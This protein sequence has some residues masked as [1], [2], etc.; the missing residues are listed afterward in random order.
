M[1][2]NRS[3]KEY[4]AVHIFNTFSRKIEAL[5]T[6]EAGL[7]KI[8]CCGPTVYESPHIGNMRTYIWQDI[9]RRTL[10]L[11][12][13]EVL[14]V[15]NITDVGHLKSDADTGEDKLQESA[16]RR[17]ST[18]WDIA[19][20]YTGEFFNYS[21]VLNIKDPSVSPMATDH[22]N[23][24]L[25]LIKKLDDNGYT[26]TIR[27]DGVYYDTSKFKD[28]GKLTGMNF[29]QLNS[30]LIGGARVELSKDKRNITDFALWKFSPKNE[31]RDM[32]WDSGYGIGFPGWHIECSAMSMKY[33]G[34]TIDVHCGGVDHIYI[35][36]PNE[37][38][39][40][41]G[42]TGKKFVNYWMHGEF[43]LVEN[44]KMS[45][46]MGNFYT[47]ADILKKGFGWREIR[48]LLFSA[49]Y[50]SQLNFTFR[51]LE[52]AKASIMRIQG[53]MRRLNRI[54]KSDDN[55]ELKKLRTLV[56][57]HKNEFL[58][59]MNNDIMVPE[60]LRVVFDLISYI[61]KQIEDD[62]IGKAGA[63]EV[64]GTMLFFDSVLGLNL[65]EL[66]GEDKV[67]QEV[68]ELL[69]KRDIARVKSDYALADEIRD[70]ILDKYGFIIED[71]K[72]GQRLKKARQ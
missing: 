61:N 58:R 56:N 2:S 9:F 62:R 65:A 45:K 8:Y 49:H 12:G 7:V 60:A 10:E 59:H 52:S 28:Y 44:K 69:D 39:Q 17:H 43:I 67:P 19:K 33:L 57:S 24:M 13:Y 70:T 30:Y 6:L 25:A 34:E 46:S 37:I 64:I 20:I 26:Y 54:N 22:I 29:A 55:A 21:R 50:R 1:P 71:S 4:G 3:A 31:K 32:E 53:I 41:E 66:M 51:G 38:A 27:N 16:N 11:N 72:D 68:I 18:A 15:R 40:S 14:H 35:H 23:D 5:R 48:Y 42:A 63:K 36:H 47:V